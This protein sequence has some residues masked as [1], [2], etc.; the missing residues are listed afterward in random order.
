MADENKQKPSIFSKMIEAGTAMLDQQIMKAKSTVMNEGLEDEF[1]YAKA[2]VDDPSYQV[3]ASGWKEKPAR[4]QIKYLYSVIRLF[5][6]LSEQFECLVN[7]LVL[8]AS[9]QRGDTVSQIV[10]EFREKQD[11]VCVKGVALRR[12]NA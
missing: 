5:D 3:Y 8:G 2:V 6:Q 1:F 9:T 12:I 10:R 11:L 4:L 7:P